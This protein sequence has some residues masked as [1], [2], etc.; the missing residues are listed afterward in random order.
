MAGVGLAVLSAVYA[1]RP[2]VPDPEAEM[3][4]TI[5]TGIF[6]IG[7]GNIGRQEKF[8]AVFSKRFSYLG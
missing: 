2:A 1:D 4:E 8:G 7:R 3:S 5:V 6:D